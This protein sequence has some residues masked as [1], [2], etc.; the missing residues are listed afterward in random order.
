MRQRNGRALGD[1]VA[2]EQAQF[3][4][5]LALRH[6]VAHRR[7]AAGNL[8]RRTELAGLVADQRRE[9]L[10]RLVCREHVVV[11]GHDGDV[12]RTLGDDLQLVVGR[13]CSHRMGDVGAAHPVAAARPRRQC[14]DAGQVG[15]AQRRAA[16]A[17][18]LRDLDQGWFH[19]RH[20]DVTV[21][22]IFT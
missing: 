18:A 13:Q 11:R 10:I 17:D 2:R 22:V 6:A 20:G 4:P 14:G 1:V 7:H 3:H 9:T 5:R 12:R 16:L 19:G 21:V 8:H 15:A